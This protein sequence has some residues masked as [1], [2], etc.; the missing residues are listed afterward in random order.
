MEMP[1]IWSLRLLGLWW[2]VKQII[3]L[4]AVVVSL[5]FN[6]IF[7]VSADTMLHCYVLDESIQSKSGLSAKKVPD[8]IKRL[9]N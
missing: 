5:L 3:F 1:G 9:V 6:E 2:L 4:I 8:G 7:E